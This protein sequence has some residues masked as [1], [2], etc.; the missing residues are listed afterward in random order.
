MTKKK[1][2]SLTNFSSKHDVK[3]KVLDC[4]FFTHLRQWVDVITVLKCFNAV[5][6]FDLKIKF[7]SSRHF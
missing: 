4:I 6:C 1:K 5:L 2:I 7:G 3:P